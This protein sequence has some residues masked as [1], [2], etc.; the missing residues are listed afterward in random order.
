MTTVELVDGKYLR[1]YKAEGET[2]LIDIEAIASWK[3]LLGLST[4]RETVAAI[5]TAQIPEE[6]ENSDRNVWTSAYEQVEKDAFTRLGVESAVQPMTLSGDSTVVDGRM[7]TREALGLPA[8]S[9]PQLQALS[10][11]G[12]SPEE[13]IGLPDYVDSDEL[14]SVLDSI[15][16]RVSEAFERF[17][18]GFEQGV[19]AVRAHE[20]ERDVSPTGNE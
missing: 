19:E 9:L 1:V 5:L 16:D 10:V 8:G 17:E 12:T 14:D 13:S 6:D 11:D 15:S 20:G 3:K 4:D 18:Q 7:A 2:H